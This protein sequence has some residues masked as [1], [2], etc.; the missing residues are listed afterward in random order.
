MVTLSAL[1]LLGGL[2]AT[3]LSP[4]SH[5]AQVPYEREATDSPGAWARILEAHDDH[6]GRIDLTGLAA[7]PA[8]LERHVHWLAPT[9]LL[10]R[11]RSIGRA[12]RYSRTT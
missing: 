1:L 11:R 9:A 5:F 8:H 12:M 10:R 2:A 7:W 4:A 6:R 3:A